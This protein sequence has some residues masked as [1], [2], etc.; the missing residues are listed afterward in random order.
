MSVSG[1]CGCP[2]SKDPTKG[3]GQYE[4]FITR[5][6]SSKSKI[7]LYIK[8]DKLI[9]QLCFVLHLKLCACATRELWLERKSTSTRAK[10]G[11]L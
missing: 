7:D 11:A 4:P 5:F 3:T 2:D 6:I 1:K 9:K 10:R 8:V